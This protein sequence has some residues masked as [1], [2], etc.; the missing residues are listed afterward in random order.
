MRCST[1]TASAVGAVLMFGSAASAQQGAAPAQP[2]AWPPPGPTISLDQA[3][4]V[5]AAAV[6]KGK[7]TPYQ[8][9]F[10]VVGPT[11]NL[12]C[13]EQEDGAQTSA[14]E[15]AINKARTAAT[16]GRPSKTFF[17]AMQAG[18]N[19]VATLAPYIVAS[20]GGLPLMAGGKV[21]GAIGV[22]GGPNG[23]ID[24]TAAQAGVDA[25]Q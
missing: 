16:F 3:T 19:F 15:I 6:A 7:T 22:S 20:P 18:H 23:L 9:A 5:L 21:I 11:G 24:Q 17:D 13:F 12:I 14:G 2:P 10:A 25:L 1:L 8:Y 4:K